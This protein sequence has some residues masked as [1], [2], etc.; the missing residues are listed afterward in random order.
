MTGLDVNRDVDKGSRA[1]GRITSGEKAMIYHH[2]AVMVVAVQDI[3]LEGF[4]ILAKQPLHSGEKLHLDFP[5]GGGVERY[6]CLVSHC[7]EKP[8]GFYIGLSIIEHEDDVVL[9]NEV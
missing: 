6:S 8:E 1:T 7:E 2:E 9:I 5:E 3:G 4:G